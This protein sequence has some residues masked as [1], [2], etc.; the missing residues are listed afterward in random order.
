MSAAAAVLVVSLYAAGGDETPFKEI[1]CPV[2]ACSADGL[3]PL[4]DVSIPVTY[5]VRID[6]KGFV[7][8][9]MTRSSAIRYHL[10]ALPPLGSA[11]QPVH[12]F[13]SRSREGQDGVRN[14]LV[15]REDAD[16]GK[17]WV[18]ARMEQ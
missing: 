7:S 16:L 14:D 3:L 8:V 15:Q 17:V 18:S 10:G 12:L 4:G 1:R 11:A 13:R 5:R 6:Q 2:P 9:E